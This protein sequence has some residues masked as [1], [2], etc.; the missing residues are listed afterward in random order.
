MEVAHAWRSTCINVQQRSDKPPLILHDDI[1]PN[2]SRTTEISNNASFIGDYT[3]FYGRN[4][5]GKS[6]LLFAKPDGCL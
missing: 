6:V 3:D 5:L 4:D 1:K 2:Q